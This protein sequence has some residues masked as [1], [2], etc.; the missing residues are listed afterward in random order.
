MTLDEQ[1]RVDREYCRLRARRT[2]NRRVFEVLR[3]GQPTEFVVHRNDRE[4]PG[5]D[6]R[7]VLLLRGERVDE[8]DR[9]AGCVEEV[10]RRLSGVRPLE[11]RRVD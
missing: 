9:L 3:N 2:A 7:W 11:G 10:A 1:R 4:P 5:S 8:R 6:R